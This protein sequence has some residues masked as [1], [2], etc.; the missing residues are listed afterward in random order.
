MVYYAE[1][2]CG[3]K[4]IEYDYRH[5]N[6][7]LTIAMKFYI[8]LL[9][10]SPAHITAQVVREISHEAERTECFDLGHTAILV[11]CIPRPT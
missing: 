7:L 11:A 6:A 8:R 4:H 9:M 2:L 1:N 3:Y 10:T 5:L